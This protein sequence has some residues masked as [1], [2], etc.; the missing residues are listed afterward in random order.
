MADRLKRECYGWM[1][2]GFLANK[3][4]SK[5][6]HRPEVGSETNACSTSGFNASIRFNTFGIRRVAW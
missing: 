2:V 5:R 1:D 6:S 4:I 3:D